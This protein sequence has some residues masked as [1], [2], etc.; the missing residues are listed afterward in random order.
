[1]K[2]SVIILIGVIYIAAIA[3][4]SFFGLQA[5]IYNAK[6]YVEKIE[7]LNDNIQIDDQGNKYV[8]IFPDEN[9]ERKYQINYRV[10]PDDASTKKVSFDYDKQNTNASVDEN[11]IVTL[12]KKGAVIV[13]IKA[14]DGS[15][16]TE[17]IE[18]AELK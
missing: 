7:I 2:K 10:Y 15:G 14:T 18:I 17:K 4:V 6:V 9:G 8:V 13:Y 12:K 1:M 5:K 16:I 11:G 3:L